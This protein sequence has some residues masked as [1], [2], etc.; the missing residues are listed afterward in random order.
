LFVSTNEIG[1]GAYTAYLQMAAQRI[2]VDMAQ[3]SL[4]GADTAQTPD[5]GTTTASRTIFAVGGAILQAAKKLEVELGRLASE[6]W[7]W[8]AGLA[9]LEGDQVKGSGGHGACADLIGPAGLSLN[10]TY[11]V[12]VADVELG[13]G[14]P[15]RFY[16]YGTHVAQVAVNVL[17]GQIVVEKVEAFLDGGQVISRSGFEGQS[18]GGIAQG[19]GYAL[20]EEVVLDQGRFKSTN[21]N[22][23]VIPT[24]L[25]MPL[26]VRT[27]PV[28][29]KEPEGPFGAKGISE[30]CMVGVAP[31]ILNAIEDAMG[32]R[33]Y[34]LPVRA[35]D[36]LQA[37]QGRSS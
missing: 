1:Q 17:T 27:V 18:E 10:A 16:S 23:Y 8:A 20:M 21:F 3:I 37:L 7:N 31:A 24:S 14:L 26:E 2:G 36:V 30:T 9:R 5:S 29:V 4:C 15:H 19:I 34:R 12:P 22:T 32:V 6:R 35:E 13:D 25:D 33:F 28:Q 11:H